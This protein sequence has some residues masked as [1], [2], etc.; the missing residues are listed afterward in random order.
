MSLDICI[1]LTD[2]DL[3]L[4]VEHMREAHKKALRMDEVSIVGAA[5]QL[6]ANGRKDLPEFI[7][8]RLKQLET[9]IEMV[10]DA[11]FGLPQE[12]RDNVLAALA[13]FASPDDALPDNVPVLGFL[14]DAIM[15]ELCLR[16]L[17]H[18]IEAYRD[19]RR[20]RD[21]QATRRHENGA[22][23]MLNRVDWAEAR[24]VEAIEQMRRRRSESYASGNWAPV[25]FHVH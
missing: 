10:E 4:F 22:Q 20:W 16:D 8:S 23:L 3:Q 21:D 1:N 5:R 13:Y 19:F 7:A 24:R 17:K 25:L 6:L 11:G 18:E 12:E 14:D 15:I 2:P 9:M